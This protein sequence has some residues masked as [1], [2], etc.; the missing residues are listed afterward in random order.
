MLL[1]TVKWKKKIFLFEFWTYVRHVW[2]TNKAIVLLNIR[3]VL[4]MIFNVHLIHM[5]RAVSS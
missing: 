2:L 4:K 3:F 5:T 1:D